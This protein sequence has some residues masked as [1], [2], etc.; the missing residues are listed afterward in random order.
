ML[1]IFPSLQP[2]ELV[3]S[4]VSR[5]ADMMV[6]PDTNAALSRI[7]HYFPGEPDV[8]FPTRL[9]R[10][11]DV[12]PPGHGYTWRSLIERHTAFPYYR[13]FLPARRAWSVENAMEW[14]ATEEPPFSRA[15]LRSTEM[16]HYCKRCVE[17]DCR[18]PA[19]VAYWRRVHQLA[20]VVVCPTHEVP[21]TSSSVPRDPRNYGANWRETAPMFA[22]LD[23]AVSL[24][25]QDL[26]VAPE[27]LGIAQAIARDSQWLLRQQFPPTSASALL[28]RHRRWLAQRGLIR[29]NGRLNSPRFYEAAREYY[30]NDGISWLGYSL[31][32]SGGSRKSYDW[33]QRIWGRPHAV[34]SPLLH[35]LLCRLYGLSIEQFFT[36]D[37]PPLPSI[38]RTTLTSPCG[39]PVCRRYDPPVPR[40]IARR[41]ACGAAYA[42][43]DCP[44]CGFAYSQRTATPGG[45]RAI[46]RVGPCWEAHLRELVT[47][48]GAKLRDV[49][50]ALGVHA[51]RVKRH[52]AELGC[53][54]TGWGPVPEPR[55]SKRAEARSRMI[56]RYRRSVRQ[57]RKYT[58]NLT[59][60]RLEYELPKVVCYLSRVDAAWL[61]AEVPPDRP[62]ERPRRRRFVHPTT[63][64]SALKKSRDVVAL[65]RAWP[66]QPVQI[67]P[68]NV[69]R[70]VGWHAFENYAYISQT[71]AY[72]AEVAESA[73]AFAERR[74]VWAAR[75][76]ATYRETPS[77]EQLADSALLSVRR[78]K[79]HR[80]SLQ[81][82]RGALQAYAGGGEPL[83]TEWTTPFP[84]LL[85]GW[86]HRW[87]PRGQVDS[88]PNFRYFFGSPSTPFPE[89]NSMGRPQ[90]GPANDERRRKAGYG[91]GKGLTY[92]PWLTVRSF[93][94]R[95]M[96]H[97]VLSTTVGRSHHLFSNVE[98]GC[99]LR[100]DWSRLVTDV[101]EQFPLHPIEETR[102]IAASLGYAHPQRRRKFKGEWIQ[103]DGVMT[104][105]FRV[106]LADGAGA[107]EVVFSVK[108]TSE[109]ANL[110]TLEK[111]EIERQYWARRGVPWY[112]ITEEQLP[113]DLIAN[114]SFLAPFR[115]V[116]GYGVDAAELPE[117][118]AYLYD[119]HAASPSVPPGKVCAMADERL[120]FKHGVCL[121][122]VWHA[123]ATRRW[124]VDLHVKLDP[125]A[126]LEDLAPG[127]SDAEP[128]VRVA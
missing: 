18:G 33:L 65:L 63:D 90:S 124:K 87:W 15:R 48:E 14:G 83:P 111:L 30:P 13:P 89:A 43:V 49:A 116:E 54:P 29:P 3:Y 94:S 58:P 108:L 27:A 67:R 115:S 59:R 4:A 97:R 45:R 8:E 7:F 51:G 20:G 96:S 28:R 53:W 95:G 127:D 10:F 81:R 125:S 109:L 1:A 98:Y 80:A 39:N 85:L 86:R 73:H 104:S 79:I 56:A 21:L 34:L 41:H 12:L 22:S 76:F 110:R 126:P 36:N 19:G 100:M 99:F 107:P 61:D 68:R 93:G 102:E 92:M 77:L 11:L 113:P 38:R 46:L 31:L 74:I 23:R 47:E 114:L 50:R 16:L 35:I 37:P 121:A 2:E 105:D 52:A 101:R 91:E 42:T 128:E 78:Q 60:G 75:W 84:E 9:R 118:L 117:I 40:T 70:Y 57:L 64:E 71:R 6:F 55:P 32:W 44:E 103:E 24:P 88:G 120:R 122:L 72:L 82:A 69:L 123:I 66:G 112:L 119:K 62:R 5:Y 26:A 17:D 106:E 25:S